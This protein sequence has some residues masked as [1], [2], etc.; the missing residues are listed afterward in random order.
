MR[1]LLL[2]CNNF[3]KKL[4]NSYF[5]GFLLIAILIALYFIP[6]KSQTTHFG[7]T[8]HSFY[9]DISLRYFMYMHTS[10]FLDYYLSLGYQYDI[11][12]LDISKYYPHYIIDFTY[13][14]L[15]CIFAILCLT[16]KHNNIKIYSFFI[17]LIALFVRMLVIVVSYNIRNAEYSEYFCKFNI[18]FYLIISIFIISICISFL[19]HY[20]KNNA[21]MIPKIES[22]FSKPHHKKA[23]P[24][25]KTQRIE[26]LEKKIEEL[27]NN[28]KVE[29]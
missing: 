13:V 9:N 17:M 24:L 15:F 28:Y 4:Q 22:R 2:K 19:L 16:K 26:L 11:L 5:L 12:L 18:S 14:A 29:N 1:W 21:A 7:T 3:F 27:E 23:K 20:F 8:L 10:E 6:Y 25:T